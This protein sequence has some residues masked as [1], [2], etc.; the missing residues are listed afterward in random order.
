MK[1]S[2]LIIIAIL[3]MG[4]AHAQ[5]TGSA[6]IYNT[7][8]GNVG[9][10]SISPDA[11]L[12]VK[13]GQIIETTGGTNTR[14]LTL[15]ENGTSQVVFGSYNGSWR[16]SIQIQN[17]NATRGL[18][19]APPET[20]YGYSILRSVNGGYKF[21]VGG[22]YANQG[23]NA[24]SVEATGNVSFPNK[25]SVGTNAPRAVFDVNQTLSAQNL[26]AVLGRMSEGDGEGEGTYLGVRAYSTT[27]G[28]FSDK[29][30]S[31]EHGFYGVINSSINFH[32]GDDRMGGFLTFNTNENNERMRITE[33]GD[34]GI[35]TAS[36]QAKLAVNGTIIS[37]KVKVTETGWADYVFEPTYALPTLKEVEAFIQA[38][39]HLPGVPSAREVEKN[40]LDLGDN[41]ATLLKKIEELTLYLLEQDKQQVKQAAQFSVL[42]QQVIRQQEEMEVMKKQLQSLL[43]AQQN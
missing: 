39:K 34:I 43:K 16:S 26:G 28:T 42:Q 31:L 27:L 23:T 24:M 7:N 3:F 38:N 17:S 36:P 10:G 19:L 11:K 1:K 4:V 32:R 12:H 9:I 15:L 14:T 35:G 20:D 29:S 41:Q 8:T 13:G 40:G 22:T 33:N 18:F 2:A 21:D 30:F 25:V 5:W 37:R 6:H